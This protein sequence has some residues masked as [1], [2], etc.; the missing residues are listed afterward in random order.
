MYIL[1]IL[2][3]LQILFL[4]GLILLKLF[5]GI[6]GFIQRLIYIFALSLIFNHLFV[7][8]FTHLE[9]NVPIAH[10]LL[11]SIEIIMA[12]YLYRQELKE[13]IGRNILNAYQVL[14]TNVREFIAP[15]GELTFQS[16]L[17]SSITILF[18]GWSAY[19]ILWTVSVLLEN[20]GSVFTIWDS[21][22]SWNH[23]AVEWFSNTQ[24]LDTKRYAQLIPT[25]FSITYSFMQ[26][27]VIQSFAIGFMPLFAVFILLLM[28]DLGIRKRD[29]GYLIGIVITQYLLKRFYLPLISSGYV[30]VALM[31]FT[32]LSVYTLL[33]TSEQDDDTTIQNTGMLGFVFVA[34]AA[35]TKQNGLWV[36]VV[37]PI[38]S[39]FLL[40]RKL[41]SFSKKEKLIL[42][43]K[44]ICLALILLLP[45]YVFNELRILEGARTNVFMLMSQEHHSGLTRIERLIKAY[46]DLSIYVY[47]FPI[48]FVTLPFID[49]DERKIIL[50]I[51][52]PYSLIWAY[53]FSLYPRNLSIGFALLGF[54]SGVGIARVAEIFLSWLEKIKIFKLSKWIPILL[55]V[56]LAFLPAILI[57]DNFLFDNQIDSQKYALDPEVNQRL[58]DYFEKEGDLKPIFTNYP[59]RFLPGFEELQIN[60]GGFEDYQFYH[61]KRAEYPEVEYMLI[62]LY[63]D[64]NEVVNE[65][66]DMIDQGYYERIFKLNKYLFVRILE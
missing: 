35:L 6:K 33:I 59:I 7:V 54:A 22:V 61:Q 51:L 48:V 45:W 56:I 64:N 18:L 55:I 24:P 4:P 46:K 49:K 60:I 27:E 5:I 66:T 17:K 25:N 8:I 1:G 20:I 63:K 13:P 50:A 15:E 19:S 32:F 31:F 65:I 43:L 16:V 12:V 10:Y 39:Y 26:S 34:G 21:V 29:F 38:L 28:L 40:F 62:S 30:D 44:Y 42:I 52:I 36:F 2:S 3:L 57:S 9:I 11:F 53:F 41:K 23:W 47:L 37:Y 14:S 58:Y